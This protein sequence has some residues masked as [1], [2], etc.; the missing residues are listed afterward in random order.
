M[1]GIVALKNLK[2]DRVY[3][4]YADNVVEDS[5]RMRF[6]LDLGMCGCKTLQEDYTETGLEL[7]RFD[8]VLETDN[9]DDIQKVIDNYPE[10]Y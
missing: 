1:S 2:T 4:F 6:E 3:L 9:P 5:A 8:T 10:R 7:F